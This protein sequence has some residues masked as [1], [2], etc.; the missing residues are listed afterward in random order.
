MKKERV[1]Q[2]TA[3]IEREVVKLLDYVEQMQMSGEFFRGQADSLNALS[4]AACRLGTLLWV[5]DAHL[6]PQGARKKACEMVF[7]IMWPIGYQGEED[8]E[9]EA[10]D[11]C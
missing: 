3:E 11:G 10:E 2:R 7:E 8:A 4:L 5:L 9:R 6:S 1:L